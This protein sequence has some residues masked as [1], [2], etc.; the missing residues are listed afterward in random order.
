MSIGKKIGLNNFFQIP[1]DVKN[2][3][4]F[5][6][7]G[8][9][10]LFSIFLAIILEQFVLFAIPMMVIVGYIAIV[11]FKK[12]FYW[13]LFLIPFSNSFAL[14][15]GMSLDLPAEPFIVA[16]MFIF[17]LFSL[18]N[19]RK[20]DIR[21]IKS[22]VTI[23][24]FFHLAWMI[25]TVLLSQNVLVSFKFF[26]S[27]MW[28]VIV[29]YFMAGYVLQNKK[30]YKNFFWYA[31]WGIFSTVLIILFR[32]ALQGFSFK[33]VNYVLNPFYSNHV[34]YSTI[35]AL[36][37]PMIWWAFNWYKKIEWRRQKLSLQTQETTIE[38]KIFYTS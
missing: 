21:F 16:L 14:P 9:I 4:A 1:A 37:T 23:L 15:G 30:D 19:W 24:L 36:F 8:L 32:H 31:F 35:L 5:L 7:F 27:K 26:L 34:K 28:Y 3:T 25:I 38:L 29:F 18:V 20:F 17:G 6:G 10:I 11:D 13:M 33:S 12:L 22:P 2:K